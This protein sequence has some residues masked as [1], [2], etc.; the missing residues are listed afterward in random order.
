MW[1]FIMS[2]E[3]TMNNHRN[4]GKFGGKHTT[5]IDCALPL[6]DLAA[7]RSEVSNISPGI[8]KTEGNS[9]SGQR[10]VKIIDMVGGIIL[11]VRQSRSVQEVRIY[12]SNI[13][14]TKFAIS[15][16][17]RERDMDLRF[18]DKPSNTSTGNHG[19]RPSAV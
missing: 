10:G 9:S 2:K 17:A 14:E 6:V 18:R 16:E 15:K 7:K 13:H 11:V 4:G 1:Y 19:T 8:I 3:A 5:F 12:T